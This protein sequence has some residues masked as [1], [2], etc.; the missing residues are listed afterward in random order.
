MLAKAKR[1][2]LAAREMTPIENCMQNEIFS[3]IAPQAEFYG[4]LRTNFGRRFGNNV[5]GLMRPPALPF[6][7]APQRTALFT[8]PPTDAGRQEA[9]RVLR[10]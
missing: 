5:Y 7:P 8:V 9:R 10:K 1:L 3:S 6:R 4:S 2:R